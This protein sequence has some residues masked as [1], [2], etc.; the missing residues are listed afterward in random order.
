MAY[1][2]SLA[3]PLYLRAC[4]T[5]LLLFLVGTL[6]YLARDI[7]VPLAFALLLAVLLLPFNNFLERKKLG[8]VPSIMITLLLG[9]V[10]VVVVVYFLATQIINFAND[11]PAIKS[12]FNQHLLSVQTWLSAHFNITKK[13][14]FTLVNNAADNIKN[15]GVIG[16]TV[17]SV[18]SI[19]SVIVLL[20]VYIFLLLY[21]RDMIYQ[22]FLKVFGKAHTDKVKEV[23]SESRNIVQGYMAGLMIE[24][25]IVAAINS[26]GLMLLGIQYAIFLGLLSAL[27]NLIPYIGMLIAS[28]FC[29]LI[30]LSTSNH[31]TDVVG[32]V[33][34]LTV[35]QFID[36]NI[37]M[38]R[39]VS[40]KVKI[41]ALITILGV[42]VG[43]ALAGVS[44][45]FLS[46]PVIAILKVIFD[47][48]ESLQAWGMLLGDDITGTNTLTI[49]RRGKSVA[50][51][52][53]PAS[54]A[55]VTDDLQS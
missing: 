40:S 25:A 14:Q 15:S 10:L 51:Q 39:V 12:Q 3:L 41:N 48:V 1:N 20:P 17:L 5:L 9:I 21:Y 29:A 22:F 49:F 36:N 19:I 45:M 30:T 31:M 43:G 34:I 47:R 55:P 2:R 6:L 32:V 8:R 38:P 42:L 52:P 26:I 11:I 54:A 33:V 16:D 27:L 24:M 35:V 46:I 50:Q 28:V 53:N 7:L 23:L 18:T 4:L 44:G 13:E 37:I